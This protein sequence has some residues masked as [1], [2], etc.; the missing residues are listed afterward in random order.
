LT[1]TIIRKHSN[2]VSENSLKFLTKEKI[3]KIKTKLKFSKQWNHF[4]N[5]RLKKQKQN[6]DDRRNQDLEAKFSRE[7]KIGG[8]HFNLNLV[9]SITE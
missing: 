2:E 7:I 5:P 8:T 1:D 9:T 4:Q 3:I 6:R